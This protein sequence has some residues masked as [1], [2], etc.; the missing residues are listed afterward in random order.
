MSTSLDQEERAAIE[1]EGCKRA[2]RRNSVEI[3]EPD[4]SEDS[5][6]PPVGKLAVETA[7]VR[8]FIGI[9]DDQPTE[10]TALSGKWPWVAQC[11]GLEEHVRLLETVERAVPKFAGAF[12]LCNGGIDPA[13]TA[14]YPQNRWVKAE[15]GRAGDSQ[16]PTRRTIFIDVDPIRP[17]GISAT[18]DERRQAHDVASK[19][20]EYLGKHLGKD[21]IGFGG[22]GNGF[23]LL[24]ALDPVAPLPEH[25]AKIT[26]FLEALQRAFGTKAV[27]I[28]KTVINPARLMAAPGTMKRKGQDTLERPHRE[29]SFIAP[30]YIERIPLSEVIG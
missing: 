21:S 11:R 10:L 12:M 6:D 5:I 8:R 2:I 30:M 9:G 15:N 29:T 14:R 4:L 1:D 28:D 20:R 7:L 23:F 13:I 19:V 22:S 16:I 24:V 27:E 25:T 18:D 3:P 26:R 17:K